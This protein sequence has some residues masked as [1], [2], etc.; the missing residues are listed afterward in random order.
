MSQ[1]DKVWNYS[2]IMHKACVVLEVLKGQKPKGKSD[3]ICHL[4]MKYSVLPH[5]RIVNTLS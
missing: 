1:P 2:T 4:M 5:W 3:K